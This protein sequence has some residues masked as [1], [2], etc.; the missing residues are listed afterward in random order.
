ML[1]N[2]I[3]KKY[4]TIT[5]NAGVKTLYAILLCLYSSVGMSSTL[6]GV[7]Y[8]TLQNEEI[9]LV[10]SLSEAIIGQPQVKTSMNPARIDITF[11]ADDFD[12][13]LLST[14]VEHAGVNSITVQKLAGLVVAS[15][16]LDKLSIFDIRQNDNKFSLTLNK[17]SANIPVAKLTPVGGDFI[18]NIDSIDFRRGLEN[19]AQVLV[20][21]EDSMVAVDVSDRKL[22]KALYRIS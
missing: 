6:T 12:L 4:K 13:E 22:G 21:L 3:M 5:R 16:N 17:S 1:L 7:K 8:N 14:T 15:I 10:F 2:N 20:Y 18:N 11:N 19:E 9:E